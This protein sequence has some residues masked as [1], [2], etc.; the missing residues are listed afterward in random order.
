MS[1]AAQ[2]ANDITLSLEST[3]AQPGD[4]VEVAVSLTVDGAMP[5]SMIV[6]L[7]Y[8]NQALSPKQDEYELSWRAFSPPSPSRTTTAM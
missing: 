6:F 2:T 5:S 7:A 1:A 3:T 8:D 4:T